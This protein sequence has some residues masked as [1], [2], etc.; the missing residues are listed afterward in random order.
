M[1]NRAVGIPIICINIQLYKLFMLDMY[2][3]MWLELG[4]A[5]TFY[6]Q[7]LEILMNTQVYMSAYHNNMYQKH[8]QHYKYILPTDEKLSSKYYS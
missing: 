4:H 1:H 8:V 3:Y 6:K 7:N 2:V 5:S